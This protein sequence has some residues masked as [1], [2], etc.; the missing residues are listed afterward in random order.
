MSRARPH[1]PFSDIDCLFYLCRSKGV[2]FS[3]EM[4]KCLNVAQI[5]DFHLRHKESIQLECS[6]FKTILKINKTIEGQQV[7]SFS[8]F[9]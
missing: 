2:L 1:I 3:H 4:T 7:K 5:Q 8:C 9:F 6:S